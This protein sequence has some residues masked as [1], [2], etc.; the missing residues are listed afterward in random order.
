MG[1]TFVLSEFRRELRNKTNKEQWH[2]FLVEWQRYGAMLGGTA[3]QQAAAAAAAQPAAS[4]GTDQHPQQQGM[5]SVTAAI[6]SG[7]ADMTEQLLQHLS[8]DQRRQLVK[9]QQ[10]AY[11]L[12]ADMLGKGDA[13]T[14]GEGEGG[15]KA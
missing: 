2:T 4:A 1:D 9:L 3:D 10:E 13:G 5:A 15:A 7:S 8:S 14:A 12:G 6:A 11:A